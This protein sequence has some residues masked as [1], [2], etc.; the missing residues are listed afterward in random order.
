[1]IENTELVWDV[2]QTKAGF[3]SVMSIAVLMLMACALLQGTQHTLN[4]GAQGA[5]VPNWRLDNIWQYNVTIAAFPGN[6]S[7]TVLVT[8]WGE[9]L[10]PN[11]NK[12]D[13]FEVIYTSNIAVYNDTFGVLYIRGRD[14]R[15]ITRTDYKTTFTRSYTN[16]TYQYGFEN[17]SVNEAIDYNKMLDP[18]GFPIEVGDTWNQVITAQVTTQVEVYKSSGPDISVGNETRS[19]NIYYRCTG[20]RDISLNTTDDMETLLNPNIKANWTEESVSTFIIIQDD[21]EQDTDGDY[22]VEYYNITKGN[23]VRKE[24][25][26]DGKINKTWSLVYTNYIFA[27]D[28]FVPPER[29]DGDNPEVY[30]CLFGLVILG[31]LVIAFIIIRKRSIPKE[32]R[33]TREYI[34][35]VDTKTELIELCEE[36]KLSTKG[37]KSQLRK[38]LLAYVDELEHEEREKKVGEEDFEGDVIQEDE[39]ELEKDLDELV[40]DEEE[41]GEG[42]GRSLS[43]EEGE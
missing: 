30:L 3:R 37:P 9:Y 12:F 36:A 40:P 29:D 42:R 26:E 31:I 35:A 21:E 13:T 18:L 43:D 7:A 1:M 39:V 38:R 16:H 10:D 22:T 11:N 33:F 27:P 6:H 8:G 23:I 41:A 25:W 14:L 17:Y 32:E 4:A 5:D 24:V 2:V 34:E 19:L 28:P 20:I 15:E